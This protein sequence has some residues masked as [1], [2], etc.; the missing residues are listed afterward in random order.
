MNPAER[1]KRET[2]LF[3][4]ELAADE[5]LQKQ[6]IQKQREAAWKKLAKYLKA[7]P[8]WK[9]WENWTPATMERRKQ[10]AL[11]IWLSPEDDQK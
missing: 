3:L 7:S 2:E 11:D 6:T 8:N 4:Q 10:R 1:Y 5:E 9:G